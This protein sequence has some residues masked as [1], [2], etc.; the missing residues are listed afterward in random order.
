MHLLVFDCTYME[1]INRAFT[2]ILVCSFQGSWPWISRPVLISGIVCGVAASTIYRHCAAV[3]A[4]IICFGK[5][6]VRLIILQCDD[7]QLHLTREAVCIYRNIVTRLL[8]I[9]TFSALLIADTISLDRRNFMA[10]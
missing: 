4:G 8:A 6:D 5:R 10:I 7:R 2:F 3:V 1:H 9:Y